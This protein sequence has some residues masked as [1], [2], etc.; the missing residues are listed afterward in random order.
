MD[1]L[2]PSQ[3]QSQ[4]QFW[5]FNIVGLY[6]WGGSLSEIISVSPEWWT[7]TAQAKAF[8]GFVLGLWFAH[9]LGLLHSHLTVNNVLLIKME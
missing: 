5:G 6:C 8:V 1:F 7:L 2:L 3:S 9:S 4:S